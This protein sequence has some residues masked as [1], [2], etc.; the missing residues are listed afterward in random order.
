MTA[1]SMGRPT[2]ELRGRLNRMGR[3]FLSGAWGTV[4]AGLIAREAKDKDAE[5]EVAIRGKGARTKLVPL[6]F[7]KN[8]AK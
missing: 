6:P 7:Y 2:Q 3:T 5:Y 8:R 1:P 4:A